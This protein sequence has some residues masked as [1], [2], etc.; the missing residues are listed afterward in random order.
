MTLVKEE[1]RSDLSK[2]QYINYI[3]LLTDLALLNVVFFT[4]ALFRNFN[5]L[6]RLVKYQ[7]AQPRE[8]STQTI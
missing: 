7:S 5:L 8:A 1:K 3:I 2:L 4:F 6:N